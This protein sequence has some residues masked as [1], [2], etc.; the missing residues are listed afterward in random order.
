MELWWNCICDRGSAGG[1]EIVAMLVLEFFHWGHDGIRLAV[2][3]CLVVEL[4]WWRW[5]LVLVVVGLEL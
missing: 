2:V 3:D 4:L 5:L 1:G